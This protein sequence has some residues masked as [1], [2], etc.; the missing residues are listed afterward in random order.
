[1][2][3]CKTSGFDWS[4]VY[5]WNVDEFKEIYHA[6]QRN[7]TRS[8]LRNFSTFGQAFGGDKKSVKKFIDDLSVWLPKE[9]RNGGAK[10]T[11]DFVEMIRKGVKLKE[12]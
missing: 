11:Q 10:G 4:E 5:E 1:M 2:V 7:D 8:T 6:L 3:Y 12:G 9:E